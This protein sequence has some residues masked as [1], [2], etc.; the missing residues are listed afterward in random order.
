MYPDSSHNI[1]FKNNNSTSVY[2]N[3][4]GNVGIGITSPRATLDVAGGITARAARLGTS[5]QKV[6]MGHYSPGETVFEIDPTWTQNQLQDYFGSSAVTWNVDSTAPGGYAIQIDGAVNV[7]G[8]S[9]YGAG[10]PHIPVDTSS[11]DLYYM[12]CWIRNEAGSSIG[13]YMGS[14]DED[15]NFSYV[16]GNPGTFTYNV[17]LNYNPGTSW[18]KVFGY[19]NGTGGSSGGA[20][21][22]NQNNWATGTKYFTPM[23]LFNYT[24]TTGPI[25]CYISGWKIMKVSYAGKRYFGGSVGIG[26]VNPAYALDVTGTIRATGDVIAYSDARV[27]DN[28]TTVENALD[29]VKSLRGVTYTRKDN[30]DKSRKVGV[31]AQEVLPILPEVVQQDT[32]GN[33]S[34]AYGNMVGVLIE[35]I[36]E[37]QKQIDE[38]KYLLQNK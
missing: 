24:Q 27:K 2:I 10:F 14:L 25:R 20:G 12:E 17:M 36:K 26:T 19:W 13:H 35:A 6:P 1:T 32:E 34:V 29:K 5:S 28:V 8:G 33:Y 18:T 30:E 22:G 9:G 21:T 16:G 23:A 15:A 37:Q 3:S 7:M 11:N 38:L 4:S 31:I